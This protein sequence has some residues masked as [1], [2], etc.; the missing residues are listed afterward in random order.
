MDS[1][2]GM[3][4]LKMIKGKKGAMHTYNV[5]CFLSQVISADN[6]EEAEVLFW[7]SMNDAFGS[8]AVHVSIEELD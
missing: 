8:N 3:V 6:E 2:D 7:E 5:S 4:N 1:K